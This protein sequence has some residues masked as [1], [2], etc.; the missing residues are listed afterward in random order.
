MQEK[1][2]WKSNLRSEIAYWESIINGTFHMKERCESF[3]KRA[4]G[5]DIL[6]EYLAQYITEGTRILDL[7][8]GPASVLGGIYNGK[9]LD[10]TAIDPL[11]EVY[12]ELY[13]KNDIQPLVIP[14]FG[15]GEELPKYVKGKFDFIYSK[16]ALDHSYDPIKCI[17]NMISLCNKD[18]VIFI[19]VSINEG[20][21]LNYSGLH[22]WNFMPHSLGG[23][24]GIVVW[25]RNNTAYLLESELTAEISSL[26]VSIRR[27]W[28]GIKIE[29]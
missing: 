29:V 10:I 25:N 23:K 8:S 6:P 15:L 26:E 18:G 21:R 11:A 27:T 22:Q 2:V 19:E 12:K 5:V 3:K 28:A 16:N 13:A 4:K 24:A 9:R 20:L 1:Y 14:E 7:G 17:N